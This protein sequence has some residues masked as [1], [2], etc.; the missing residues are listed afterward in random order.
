MNLRCQSELLVPLLELETR[1]GRT[2]RTIENWL[3]DEALNFPKPVF[4]R[5]RR[6]FS[7]AELEKFERRFADR[8]GARTE[9]AA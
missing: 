1:Y 6:Y 4:V 2:R 7:L 8:F 5:G 3:A 9:A